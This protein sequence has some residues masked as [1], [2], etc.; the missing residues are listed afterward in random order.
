MEL[1]ALQVTALVVGLLVTGGVA[2][3]LAG[4]LGVGGGIV[5]VPILFI[6]FDLLDFSEAVAM[7]LAVATSLATIIPTSMSSAR[8]HHRKGNVDTDLFKRW[9]PFIALGAAV[10][11]LLSFVVSGVGLKVIFGTV[12]LA[13]AINM[14]SPKSLVLGKQ[15]PFGKA[16]NGGMATAIGGFSALMGIGGGTLSVPVLSMF[17]FPTH[18]AVGTASA[19]GIVIAVPAVI[20]FIASGIGVADRPPWSFGY[21]NLAAAAIIFPVTTLVAPMGARIAHAL[22]AER[23]RLVFAVFLAITAVRMLWTAVV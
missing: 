5:I 14:A 18:R 6:V 8:A 11:G 9:A 13:V 22:P 3:L 10:G 7:P 17:S 21:V 23:L 15:L 16:R 4:L 1:D 2:G 20:G 12:A 19:F